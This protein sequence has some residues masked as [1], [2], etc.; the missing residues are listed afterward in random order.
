[1][2]KKILVLVV[3][4]GLG[5]LG[6]LVWNHSLSKEEKCSVKHEVNDMGQKINTKAKE[7]AKQATEKVKEV[8]R[9]DK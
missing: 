2:F 1:M 7:L 4:V 8:V 6:Y 3:L 9:G 5:Y